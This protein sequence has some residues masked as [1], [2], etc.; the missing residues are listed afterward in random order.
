MPERA[1]LSSLSAQRASKDRKLKP[2]K[3]P[4]A[5]GVLHHLFLHL[6][7]RLKGSP[8][9]AVSQATLQHYEDGRSGTRPSRVGVARVS[10]WHSALWNYTILLYKA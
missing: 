6:A 5:C 2:N 9:V 3:L 4:A 1:R 8:A 10:T 7:Q